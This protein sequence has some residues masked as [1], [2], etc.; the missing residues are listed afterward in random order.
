MFPDEAHAAAGAF[1]YLTKSNANYKEDRNQYPPN[2]FF[3]QKENPDPNIRILMV[4]NNKT[5]FNSK[6][7]IAF[8]IFIFKWEDM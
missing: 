1:T 5:Q 8:F 2:V 3:S 6:D 4:F 7:P